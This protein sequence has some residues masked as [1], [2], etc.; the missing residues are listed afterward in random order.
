MAAA[1][2]GKF[3]AF[4]DA[5]YARHAKFDEAGIRAVARKAGLDMRAFD[6]AL[7][8]T[9]VDQQVARDVDLAGKLGIRGT[10]AY[11]VN[12]RPIL[13]AQPEVQFILVIEE[14]LQ[15]AAALR[16]EG[17]APEDLYREL[18]SRPLD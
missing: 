11:F 1:A 4:H 10:P 13:G 2:Q 18:T 5:L 15:R 12:G 9:E 14:E 17:V 6:R 16:E 7:S 3:W 8:G